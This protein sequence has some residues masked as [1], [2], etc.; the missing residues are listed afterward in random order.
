MMIINDDYKANDAL[1]PD[2]A[3]PVG[4][5]AQHITAATTASRKNATTAANDAVNDT[6]NLIN[7]ISLKNKA[8][9]INCISKINGTLIDNAE[10]LDVA[11]FR[12]CNA[13][14]QFA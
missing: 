4:S 5:T 11:R 12:C 3:F 1:F 7:G 9:F 10:H 8:S 13:Y 6:R 2:H 14:I